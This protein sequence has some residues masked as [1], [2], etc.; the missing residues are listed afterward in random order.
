MFDETK[1]YFV[2]FSCC[3]QNDAPRLINGE[4]NA[5]A[6]SEIFTVV[7]LCFE[8]RCY[9]A[10]TYLLYTKIWIVSTP[11][12]MVCLPFYEICYWQCSLVIM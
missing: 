8:I 6:R 7:N 2:Q 12:N 9:V 3:I 11:K 5:D 4:I 10:R 1:K